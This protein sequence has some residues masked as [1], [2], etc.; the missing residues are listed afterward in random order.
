MTHV[1]QLRI[2]PVKGLATLSLDE[3]TLGTDGVAEDRRILLLD[4]E[5]L[6]ITVRQRPDFV[7]LTPALDLAAGRLTVTFPDSSTACS[8]LVD[9]SESASTTLF[10]R[11]RHGR[12]LPGDVADALTAFSGQP[13]RVLVTD[14]PGIGPDEGPVSV[15]SRASIREV[16]TPDDDANRYR[17]LLTVDGCDA[18][19][20]ET[21]AG[22]QVK[23]GDAV[24]DISHP[25]GRCLVIEHDPE[26]GERDWRGLRTLAIR[27]GRDQITLG[28][29]AFVAEPGRIRVGDE[30][31]PL[32]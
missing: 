28:V 11:E 24:L 31:L 17:M 4:A 6:V 3:I 12:L 15:V 14:G 10:R 1:A 2:A 32:G 22:R 7:R 9:A 21:W 25:L 29:I 30:V 5:G 13:V 26:T 18:H 27:R 8:S 20:E 16:E 23:I 19:A